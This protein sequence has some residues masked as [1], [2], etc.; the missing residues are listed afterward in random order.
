[1]AEELK[2]EKFY[3]CC[4]LI[5]PRKFVAIGQNMLQDSAVKTIALPYT[6]RGSE[7]DG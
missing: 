6:K 4:S 5:S 1:M 7:I 3:K 2:E